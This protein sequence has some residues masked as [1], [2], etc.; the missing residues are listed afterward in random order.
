LRSFGCS[1]GQAVALN[2]IVYVS[3]VSSFPEKLSLFM[4]IALLFNTL[5][6]ATVSELTKETALARRYAK[7]A[8]RI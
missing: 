5:R 2:S 6:A 3:P 1:N 7:L 8:G 4:E